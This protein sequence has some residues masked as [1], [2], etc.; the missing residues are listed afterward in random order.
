MGSIG[1]RI[2]CLHTPCVQQE[3]QIICS[4]TLKKC[5]D[6]L[7]VKQHVIKY[8]VVNE[9]HIPQLDECVNFQRIKYFLQLSQEYNENSEHVFY[10]GLHR[11]R[12]IEFTF[13]MG[14]VEYQ[15][16]KEM[17]QTM[18][19]IIIVDDGPRVSDIRTHPDFRWHPHRNQLLRVPCPE[20]GS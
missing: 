3:S 13:C 7:V 8:S 17:W 15:F 14:G 12:D 9:I 19:G 1:C 6:S 18:F 5:K 10:V 16:M 2:L 4:S 20:K 11:R